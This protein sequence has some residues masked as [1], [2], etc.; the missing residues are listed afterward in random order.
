MTLSMKNPEKFEASLNLDMMS[1]EEI[2]IQHRRIAFYSVEALK[3]AIVIDKIHLTHPDFKRSLNAM[4]RIFQLAPEM[5]MAQ[6]MLLSGPTGVGKTA[7]FK[8]F[9]DSLPASNLF[10]PGYGALGLRCPLR[11]T[12][13][14]FIGTLL[15]AYKFPFSN[16]TER[17]LYA[18][19]S[20]VFDAI[21]EK[22]TRLMFIDEAGGFLNVKTQTSI[23]FGETDVSDFIREMIDECGMGVV[24]ATSSSV[25]SLD[26]LD[27]SLASR[28]TV[29]QTL[30]EF[31]PDIEWLGVLSAFAKQCNSYDLSFIQTPVIANELHNATNG[32]LRVLKRL[33]IES[34]LIGVDSGKMALDQEVLARAFDL[35]FGN[36]AGRTNV[37]K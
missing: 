28:I 15:R 10:A 36:S 22:K 12:V 27:S 24:L 18:R 5:D 20:I 8:Y 35:I 2:E 3:A 19:R 6:G 23:Q 29:R 25:D 16:G 4:D 17:Q 33:M 9:R 31:K 26:G 1:V 13:G 11:P 14:F 34:V 32:N 21:R 30:R 37:F 7:V